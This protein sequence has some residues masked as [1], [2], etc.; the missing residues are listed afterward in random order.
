[1]DVAKLHIDRSLEDFFAGAGEEMR[2]F[3]AEILPVFLRKMRWFHAKS[4][5]IKLFNLQYAMPMELSGG[6]ETVILLVE[7]V[8]ETSNTETYFLPVTLAEKPEDDNSVICEVNR[9][10][11]FAGYLVDALYTE[12]FRSGIFEY[13]TQS[14]KLKLSTGFLQFKMG[15]AL[16]E[17]A[18]GRA[19][20]SEVLRLEQ[21]N[22]TLVYGGNF[23]LKIY[24][25]M[26]RDNNPDVEMT[27]FLSEKSPFNNSPRFAGSIEWT[28]ND[29][30][31]VSIGL[32]Q[33]KVENDGE[34]WND[35]L[36]EIE[37]FFRRFA[38]SE[39]EM[40]DLPKVELY[41]PLPLEKV[42]PIFKELAGSSML[43]KVKKLAIR[44]AEM[45]IALF[46]DRVDRNFTPES[47]SSDYSVW[48]L[49]RVMYMLDSRF[50]LLV[51]NLDR[52]EGKA[53]QYAEEIISRKEEI[54][55]RILDF[56][57]QKLNSARIR[58]H[59]DYHLGQILLTGNDFCILDFEG[60]PESTIRDRKVKQPPMKD[61]AGLFRSYHYAVF[62][63]VFQQNHTQLPLDLLT[64]AGGRYY[65]LM[66]G[67]SLYYYTKTAMDGGLNIGYASEIDFLLR[68]HIFEKAIYELGYELH[69]RPDWVLIPLKGIMQILNND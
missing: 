62:A 26:F 52:L 39:Y 44:T 69:A 67:L 40:D 57:D 35:A 12:P 60:E 9:R 45:H 15:K 8:F 47:F 21:S 7:I 36:L 59:G 11:D 10:G 53:R 49:N 30:Y 14:R 55:D 13:I 46:H 29:K 5:N 1:M 33:E 38:E 43:E 48:L 27:R 61:L 16:R 56:D 68:Y 66:V 51:T 20:N 6:S 65:R 2:N 23:Y 63:T 34:A 17:L 41:K 54:K 22:S 19:P 3:E 50:N 4:S 25:K 31:S 24:R 64:E 58:I 42:P 28:P 32:M 37:G 18:P